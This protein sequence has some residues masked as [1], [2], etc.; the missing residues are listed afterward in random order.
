[1]LHTLHSN[2]HTEEVE[3]PFDV[4]E[5]FL[6]D[7]QVVAVLTGGTE[8]QFVQLVKD[9][10]IDLTKPIYLMVSGHSNS[11]AASL[12]ILSYIRQ[13]DGV[14]RVHAAL[15]VAQ[16]EKVDRAVHHAPVHRQLADELLAVEVRLQQRIVALQIPV[17]G[18]DKCEHRKNLPVF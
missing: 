17:P 11:L 18:F 7:H 12:E 13:H 4:P 16:G 3:L 9:K 1:M 15:L 6:E 10:K 14:A 8:S 5:I 2:L